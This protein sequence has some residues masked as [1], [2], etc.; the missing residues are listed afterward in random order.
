[1]ARMSVFL[2]GMVW[3]ALYF[4]NAQP[5]AKSG[6]RPMDRLDG[7]PKTPVLS[8]GLSRRANYLLVTANPLQRVLADVAIH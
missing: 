3:K 1:M 4:Q 5:P 7:A 6:H 8:R 2:G